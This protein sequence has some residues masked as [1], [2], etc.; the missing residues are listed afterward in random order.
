VGFMMSLLLWLE[1][2]STKVGFCLMQIITRF[3]LK[4]RIGCHYHPRRLN[5]RKCKHCKSE[6]PPVK[7]GDI[8]QKKGFCDVD[9][10]S[11]YGIAKARLA[12]KKKAANENKAHKQKK[13]ELY[14]N[15]L[16]W[17]HKQTQKAFNKMRVLQELKWFADRGLEPEC[18]SC[19]KKNM[20]WCCGHFKT[21]GASG[22]L[23]YANFNS[24]LQ[25]NYY[26]NQ[27]LS[28]NLNGTATTRGYRAGLVVR[29]GSDEAMKR[30]NWLDEHQADVKKW[31]CDELE[32]MRKGFNATIRELS[33]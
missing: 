10:M 20:D 9:H 12:L 6:L 32:E 1:S 33:K 22:S 3:T 16:S 26:C 25:C 30:L 24:S 27:S 7:A 19:G 14:R 11:Q 4:H 5:M 15:D 31:T 29:Y 18:I 17:Q 13:R 21:V 2:I 8:W 28:G 23:R